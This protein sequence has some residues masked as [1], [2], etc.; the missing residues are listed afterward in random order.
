MKAGGVF[1]IIAALLADYVGVSELLAADK[2]PLLSLPT[3]VWQ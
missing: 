1:G 3:G 2:R